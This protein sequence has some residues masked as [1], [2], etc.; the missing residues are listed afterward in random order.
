[1]AADVDALDAGE[2]EDVFDEVGE[3]IG[4]VG[5][6]AEVLGALFFFDGAGF[7]HVGVEAEGGEGGAEFVG[8]GGDEGG[9]AFAEADDGEDE[10]CGGGDGEEGGGPAKDEGGEDGGAER[11]C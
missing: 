1:V 4:F 3:P 2:G 5:E 8:D 6:D 9:A 11:F 10:E 7:E